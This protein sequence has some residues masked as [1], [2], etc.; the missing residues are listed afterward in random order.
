LDD[1]YWGKD[2]QGR[3]PVLAK[4]PNPK[5]PKPFVSFK[6]HTAANGVSLSPCSSFGFQGDAFVALFGDIAPI[7]TPRLTAP[8]GYKIV[9]VDM[10]K[11]KIVDFAVNKIAG[12]ASQLHHGGF[13]RPSH[14]AFGPDGA[15]YVVDYGKIQIAPEVGGVRMV[16]GTGTLWRIRPTGARRGTQPPKPRHVQLYALQYGLLGLAVGA[17]FLFGILRLRQKR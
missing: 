12:P 8:R 9:R 5:P 16:L 14:C 4:L 1:R 13:E 7:T 3:E 11:R 15:L 2:G 6:P 17:I 10:R